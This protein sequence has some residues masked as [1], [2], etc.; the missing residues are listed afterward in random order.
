MLRKEIAGALR[1]NSALVGALPGGIYPYADNDPTEM[2]STHYPNAFDAFKSILAT[3]LVRDNG[4]LI[5]GPRQ[6]HGS[7]IFFDLLFWEQDTQAGIEAAMKR[8]RLLLDSGIVSPAGLWIYEIR[9]AGSTTGIR[10]PG[11]DD[12]RHAIQRWQA[13]AVVKG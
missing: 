13:T 4:D 2:S 6:A 3:C 11:L 1:A 5:A 7:A 10:D 8:S 12:A 9:Y